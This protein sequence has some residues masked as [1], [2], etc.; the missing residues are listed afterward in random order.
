MLGLR[1]EILQ[2]GTFAPRAH[3]EGIDLPKNFQLPSLQKVGQDA[4]KL[5]KIKREGGPEEIQSVFMTSTAKTRGKGIP[6]T[7]PERYNVLLPDLFRFGYFAHTSDV[8]DSLLEDVIFVLKMFIRVMEE[9]SE[10]QLRAMGHI[11]P[12]QKLEVGKYFILTNARYKLCVHLLKPKIDRP[13]EAI[14]FL[15]ISVETDSE[16]LTAKGKVPWVE[17]PFLFSLYAEALVFAGEYAEAKPMLGRVLEAAERKKDLNFG[18]TIIRTRIHLAQVLLQLGE[19]PEAQKEHTEYAVKFLRK[20][21][22]ILSIQDLMQILT[23]TDQPTHPVLEA[24]GGLT[25]LEERRNTARADERQAKQC[26]NC[27]IREPQKTLFRCA[28]CQHIYYCSKECQKANWKMH[29]ESC[30]ETAQSRERAEILKAINPDKGRKAADWIE[31]RNAPHEANTFALAHALGVRRDPSRGRTHILL[32]QVE[33]VPRAKDIRYRFRVSACGVYRI[34]DIL[35]DIEKLMGLDPGEG[36][37]YIDGLLEELD[38]SSVGTDKVPLLDLTTGTGIE[39][40]LGSMAIHVDK[41][42]AMPYDP[43]WR[44]IMNRG[45]ISDQLKLVSGAKDVEHV[46]D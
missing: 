23:R 36:R 30:K 17:N 18:G 6:M 44:K 45:V 39:T 9:S 15:K 34:A 11:L 43:D 4:V 14:P 31:W 38:N 46:F 19:E 1:N 10:D 29:K 26:R 2:Q 3:L 7:E 16:R 20:N 8:P 42:R 37:E 25:W 40:W 33:Y 13:R 12:N 28:Q 27:G 24:I 32:R 21:P 41:L 22:K 35:T 5:A